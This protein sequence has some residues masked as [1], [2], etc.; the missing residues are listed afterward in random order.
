MCICIC[1][2][3][4]MY[5]HYMYTHAY[6]HVP[7]V[8]IHAMFLNKSTHVQMCMY[9]CMLHANIIV[10]STLM[11]FPGVAFNVRRLKV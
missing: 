10:L 7:Y 11:C 4:Y 3:E 8:S 6:V 9:A 2:Y 5:I 1:V